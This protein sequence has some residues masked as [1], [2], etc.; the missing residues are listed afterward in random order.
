MIRVL[1]FVFVA[2]LVA[3]GGGVMMLGAFPPPIHQQM[4]EKVVPNDRF[5]GH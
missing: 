5:Q 1:M 3:I 2:G 4:V